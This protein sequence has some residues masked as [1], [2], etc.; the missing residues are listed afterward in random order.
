MFALMPHTQAASF[1][2]HT[3]WIFDGNAHRYCFLW[4]NIRLMI[5]RGDHRMNLSNG[6]VGVG[7][8]GS[9]L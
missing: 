9:N 6:R 1:L 8:E 5:G 4:V 2:H 7:V 3:Y